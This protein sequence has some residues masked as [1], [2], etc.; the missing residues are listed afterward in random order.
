[1]YV[2]IEK[3]FT[4]SSGVHL[5]LESMNTENP[6][7]LERTFAKSEGKNSEFFM[8]KDEGTYRGYN[9][10]CR[11]CFNAILKQSENCLKK[12]FIFV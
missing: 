10:V 5:F 11:L 4:G 3:N 9:F 12:I 7:E 6:V 1:M 2:K 8:I